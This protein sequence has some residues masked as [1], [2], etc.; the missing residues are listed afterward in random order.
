MIKNYY[1]CLDPKVIAPQN[2][3]HELISKTAKAN[4]G[5]IVFYGSEDFFVSATQPFIYEK[6]KRTPNLDGVIFFTL[7]QF[8]Y[9]HEMNFPLLAKILKLELNIHF[10]R[11]KISLLTIDDFQQNFIQLRSYAHTQKNGF[12]LET[13]DI[14]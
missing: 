1:S 11:E 13:P 2:E 3:Q 12:I 8:C 14:I 5:K 10:A 4:G 7:N 9:G 6:L